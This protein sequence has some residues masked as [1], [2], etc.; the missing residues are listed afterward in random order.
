MM[1]MKQFLRQHESGIVA[2]DKT[3][4]TILIDLGVGER[5][6][7]RKQALLALAEAKGHEWGGRPSI[8]KLIVALADSELKK[9]KENGG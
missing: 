9:E 2:D 1:A 5:G 7:Q 4:T 3:P 6:E 8:G